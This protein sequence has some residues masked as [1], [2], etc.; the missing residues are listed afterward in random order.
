M[1]RRSEAADNDRQSHHRR[2]LLLL[3]LLLGCNFLFFSLFIIYF[4]LLLNL[5]TSCY[6]F[7]FRANKFFQKAGKFQN[8]LNIFEI[9]S[10]S[11]YLWL[12]LMYLW[13]S[14]FI[15]LFAALFSKQLS[16][17][18]LLFPKFPELFSKLKQIFQN[19]S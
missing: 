3:L 9:F 1:L 4:P 2:P 13:K 18:A 12:I 5:F 14:S 17:K 16:L 10:F 19:F 7:Q 8:S 11:M 6:L 15:S